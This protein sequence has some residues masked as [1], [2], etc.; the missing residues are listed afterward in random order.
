ML[1]LAHLRSTTWLP[2]HSDTGGR[3]GFAGT[4]AI[5]RQGAT[6]SCAI[7]YRT[8][9]LA[10]QSMVHQDD[11]M[12]SDLEYDIVVPPPKSRLARAP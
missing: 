3:I 11:M 4:V 7:L 12:D 8:T 9:L 5:H 10:R 1:L 2:P 6:L